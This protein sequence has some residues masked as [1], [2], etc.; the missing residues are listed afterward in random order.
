MISP[1]IRNYFGYI[2]IL[3]FIFSCVESGNRKHSKTIKTTHPTAKN[4]PPDSLITDVLYYEEEHI[5]D[6]SKLHETAYQISSAKLTLTIGSRANNSKE[7]FGK[8]EDIVVDKEGNIFV[9]DQRLNLIKV[10]NRLGKYLY[11]ISKN[12]K[13]PGQLIAGEAM[14]ISR[15]D[16]YLYVLD[17]YLKLEIFKKKENFYSN[18]KTI[19]LSAPS[20]SGCYMNTDSVYAYTAY[21]KKVNNFIH[22]YSVPTSNYI[23][24][25][26]DLYKSSLPFCDKLI[27]YWTYSL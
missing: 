10:F 6:S 11:T 14:N 25:Y 4:I 23:D 21:N 17:R 3:Y 22:T 8:I 7:I 18:H 9:L 1:K 26:G 24:S 20:I 19:K 27:V 2:F 13:G 12:G 5:K 15:D 16:N